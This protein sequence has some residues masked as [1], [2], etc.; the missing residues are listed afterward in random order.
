MLP[1]SPITLLFF[2]FIPLSLESE[3]FQIPWP[4]NMYFN[5]KRDAANVTGSRVQI[6]DLYEHLE[7]QGHV[8]NKL[9]VSVWLLLRCFFQLSCKIENMCPCYVVLCLSGSKL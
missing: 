6:R 1:R 7:R 3:V 4:I 9:I 5:F 8:R 2:R